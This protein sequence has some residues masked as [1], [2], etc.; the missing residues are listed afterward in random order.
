MH[1]CF[2][3]DG[4]IAKIDVAKEA[5]IRRSKT[6]GEVF[7]A[8]WLDEAM[9]TDAH[10]KVNKKLIS[11]YTGVVDDKELTIMMTDMFKYHYLGVSNNLKENVLFEGMREVISDLHE[12]NY[13]LSIATTLRKDIVE[14]VLSNLGL[15]DKFSYIAG[16]NPELSYD[17]NSLVNEVCK[18][19]GKIN[20]MIGDKS[21][22]VLAGQAFDAK[23]ILVS[24]GSHKTFDKADYVAKNPKDLYEF[25][26]KQ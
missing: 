3:W 23:G 5:A 10:Y 2:D 25:I 22:D 26:T 14:Q 19:I 18:H 20:Y 4:T 21:D 12:Q 13:T 9:K 15:K 11:D 17:K 6:L 7:D 8:D 16:N 24:W 1:I